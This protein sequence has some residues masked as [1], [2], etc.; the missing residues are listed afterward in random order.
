MATE[1]G[2]LMA[3]KI[4]QRNINSYGFNARGTKPYTR[5]A[6]KEFEVFDSDK[7]V[8]PNIEIFSVSGARVGIIRTDA[9]KSLLKKITFT[10]D[11]N[12]CAD[13][14]FI[15]NTLPSFEILPFSTIAMNVGGA[16]KD[17]FRGVI[18]LPDDIQTIKTEYVFKG[19]GFRRYLQDLKANI[20][21]P[22]GSDISAIV[23]K[24]ARV[25]IAPYSP[26]NY[27]STLIDTPTGVVLT[28]AIELGKY[29]IDIIL[30][31]LSQMTHT[32]T[33]YYTWGVDGE[34]DFYFKKVLKNVALRSHF[35]GYTSQVFSGSYDH[36]NIKNVITLTRKQ[37]IAT[38]GAGWTVAGVYSD[39]A[40][41]AKYGRNEASL[42]LPGYFSDADADLVGEALLEDVKEPAFKAKMSG[43]IAKKSGDFLE[44][45]LHRVLLHGKQFQ[46]YKESLNDLEDYTEFTVTTGGGDFTLSDDTTFFISGQS[47]V[48]IAFSAITGGAAMEMDAVGAGQI[49]EIRFYIRSD[50]VGTV[51]KAGVGTGSFVENLRSV[52]VPL[53]NQFI[54]IVL[55]LENA[56]LTSISK[57]GLS[58]PFYSGGGA[59]NLWIDKLDIVY[60]GKDTRKMLFKRAKYTYSPDNSDTE[61]EFGAVTKGLPQYVAGLQR[62]TDDLMFTGEEV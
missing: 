32:D 34:G 9:Q 38:G 19:F 62:V 17:Q 2:V 20:V 4:Q 53:I 28:N 5:P 15:L 60:K 40:S 31:I 51:F 22:G 23:D 41:I 3:F 58:F 30:D 49:K 57:F 26:I 14:E 21:Y 39:S 44:L 1:G 55:D 16:T 59:R 10:I 46:T 52:D 61:V 37:S 6:L 54:P 7:F 29:S 27:N 56:G 18:T 48:K 43:F 24:I 8:I 50:R 35:V 33:Y 42:Q 13:F 25:E 12:G 47:S 45:G 11:E 36:N